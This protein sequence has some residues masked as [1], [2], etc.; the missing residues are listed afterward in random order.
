MILAL[1]LA[2]TL[3]PCTPDAALP[4]PLSG[5]NDRGAALDGGKAVTMAAVDPASVRLV[6]VPRP[7]QA[8]RVFGMRFTVRRAGTYGLALDQKGWI[9]LYTAPP[10]G[11]PSDGALVSTA[12][13]HGP[14]CSTIRKIVR[15]RLQPGAYQLVVSGLERPLAKIMLVTDA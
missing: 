5:W 9:D 8:G 11:R 13:E 12:H 1:L 15:F 7:K 4:P 10:L 14:R 2:Q 6:G 3:G